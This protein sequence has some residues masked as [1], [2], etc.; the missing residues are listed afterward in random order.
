MTLQ[1]IPNNAA[2][3]GATSEA[4]SNEVLKLKIDDLFQEIESLK[5]RVAVLERG[6]VSQAAGGPPGTNPAPLSDPDHR[7]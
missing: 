7:S 2:M 4:L 1:Q 6:L 5:R 3:E